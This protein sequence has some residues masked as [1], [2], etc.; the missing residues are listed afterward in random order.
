[1][2]WIMLLIVIGLGWFALA[3]IDE[4]APIDDNHKYDDR[5]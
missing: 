4:H 5:D 1:M 3:W 2:W